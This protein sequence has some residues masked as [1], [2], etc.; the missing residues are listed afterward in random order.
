[1]DAIMWANVAALSFSHGAPMLASSQSL[2]PGGVNTDTCRKG[3]ERALP[4][5][6]FITYGDRALPS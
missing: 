1:M 5:G 2:A 6:V 4:S 3:R